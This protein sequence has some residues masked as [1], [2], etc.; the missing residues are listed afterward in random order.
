[1]IV[2]LKFNYSLVSEL[3]LDSIADRQ[4]QVLNPIAIV[5]VSD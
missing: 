2:S 4:C 5:E 3:S 1:M